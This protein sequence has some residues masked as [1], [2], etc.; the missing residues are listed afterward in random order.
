MG[1]RLA[2]YS[3]IA[4]GL[5]LALVL[6]WILWPRHS[7]RLLVGVD[8]DTLKWT[9]DPVSVVRWQHELGAEAVRVWVVAENQEPRTENP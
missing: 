2:R 5:G 8:D 7:Q 3:A 9:A 1:N 4:A 6:I